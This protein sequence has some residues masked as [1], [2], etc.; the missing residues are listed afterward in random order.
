[1]AD[2]ESQKE[3]A[4]MEPEGRLLEEAMEALG[5][6]S[7][8]SDGEGEDLRQWMREE[9]MFNMSAV[10]VGFHLALQVAKNP[11]ALG[12]YFHWSLRTPEL[13]EERN[14]NL[15]PLPL[16]YDSRMQLRDVL[17]EG[18]ALDRPGKWRERGEKRSSAQKTKRVEG[19][20]VWHRLV[21]IS[22]N[23]LYGDRKKEAA[24]L[25][26]GQA[27]VTQEKAL[28]RLW[29]Q[30]KIF[31]DEKGKRGVPRSPMAEWQHTIGDL[32]VSYTGEI[33]E[34]ASW[35]TL[36][37]ILPGLP[38]PQHGGLVNLLE[39]VPE[40]IAERLKDPQSLIR[41]D[42]PDPMP[43]PRVMCEEEE[44]K[45]VVKAMYERGLVQAAKVIP[46]IDGQKVLNGAFGVPK[47]GKT[48]DTGEEV[49]RF[50][51]D[52][53]STNWMMEQLVADTATLTGAATFQRL[54]VEDNKD[55]LISGE[56]LTS[57]F[58]L[59]RL[60]SE[61][62]DFMV[63]DRAV[64]G[65]SL[66]LPTS[67][68]VYA[69][70]CVL[71]MGWHS[72]VGIMQAA[73]RRIAL[74]SQLRGGAG[75]EALAEIQKSA[76]FP[77]LDEGP[78]WSIYLDDTTI[79]E[80]VCSKM[81]DEMAGKEPAVQEQLRRAY[82]WWGIPTNP[83]KSLKRERVAERLG[84]VIDGKAGVLRASTQR[85]L[86]V[87]SLG[88]W[89][90]MEGEVPRKALQVYAG[91]MVHILQFRRCM[92]S[93]LEEIFSAISRGPPMVHVTVKLRN[94]MLMLEMALP[95]A[96]FNLRA[97]VDPVVTCS[98]ACETGGGIC[99]SSRLSRAG[100]E[101]V[102]AMME[103]ESREKEVKSDPFNLAHE[104]RVVVIDLFSGIGGLTN[105]LEKAGV[106]WHLLVC[107]EKDKDCRRLLRRVHPGAELINDV[108]A[109][110]E[111]TLRRL[112]GK[113]PEVTGIVVGGGSPCQG[114]SK[115]KS[116]RKHLHDERSG[117]FFEVVRIF[118]TM[119]KLA[120]ERQAWLLKILENVVADVSDIR[121]MSYEVDIH[122]V[123]VDSQYL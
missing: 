44:W 73:H 94:E 108:K 109:L 56:D 98:D 74:G 82:A 4:E 13:G 100:K 71:P 84:A 118:Q 101:E 2:V 39:V 33:I 47:P 88:S 102:E 63:L 70:L 27:S 11:G 29:N 114:L 12:E 69:G 6:W 119:E 107:V 40:D 81:A 87:I 61:W 79:L 72:S 89:I 34:K 22:L 68:L 32:S 45:E 1:M 93:Y 14:R 116:Q 120:N 5:R 67:E 46:L 3:E 103:G 8:A 17:E 80:K 36:R 55:L 21:V 60:P 57:A 123:M 24:P 37:Q 48:L 25:P 121:D 106:T 62:V 26:G 115:L 10:Q 51:M 53:R 86:E 112:L 54:V 91:K 65:D 30:L 78:G 92:F 23:Y 117:L 35:L 31:I 96:Q 64:P 95:L 110:D 38:S 20:K 19:L 77:D 49:L 41:M 50:I 18:T 111:K 28:T 59:F 9:P 99:V 83:D 7:N 16:W 52:L 58:Y 104:E 90:R 75:L 105:A 85:E 66:G 43:K 42:F 113:M 76:I 15:F 97:V 122:P